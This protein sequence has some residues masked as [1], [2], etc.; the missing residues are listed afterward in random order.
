MLK[1][2]ART[3]L[4]ATAAVGF[5]LVASFT[6]VNWLTNCQSWDRELWTSESSCVTPR[7]FI[8]GL[9]SMLVGK[10]EAGETKSV[11]RQQRELEDRISPSWERR[12]EARDRQRER[13]E[14]REERR[15]DR[16]WD[17]LTRTE[18]EE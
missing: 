12:L 8:D 7:E 5:G 13:E 14:A 6:T 18:D 2:L 10:A 1:K 17:Q 3:A 4:A 11:R 9:G 16:E 15:R